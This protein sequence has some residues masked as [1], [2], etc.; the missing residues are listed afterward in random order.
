MPQGVLKS[1]NGKTGKIE[2]IKR[3]GYYILVKFDKPASKW[4]NGQSEV[5]GFHFHPSELELT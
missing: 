4:W 1:L 2:E 3:D 5:V